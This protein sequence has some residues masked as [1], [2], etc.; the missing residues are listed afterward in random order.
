[1]GIDETW[2]KRMLIRKKKFLYKLKIMKQ[3]AKL[4]KRKLDVFYKKY[5]KTNKYA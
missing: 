3:K 2:K 4:S 1:M 5:L